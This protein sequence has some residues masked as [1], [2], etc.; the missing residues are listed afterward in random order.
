[1]LVEDPRS[2]LLELAGQH[3]LSD[4]LPLAVRRL[5]EGPAVALVRIWLIRPPL[6]DDCMRCRFAAECERRDRCLHLVAGAGHSADPRA[7]AWDRLDG[8]FRRFPLGV[9]KSGRS[10]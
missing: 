3:Q 5:A 4:L 10:P 6:A 8:A 2:I 1:M 7:R 9:R